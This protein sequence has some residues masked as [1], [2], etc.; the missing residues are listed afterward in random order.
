MARQSCVEPI[1]VVWWRR[2]MGESLLRLFL[3]LWLEF[4]IPTLEEFGDDADYEGVMI[5]IRWFMSCRHPEG[6]V[7]LFK[8]FWE[9]FLNLLA[10]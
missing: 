5:G 6:G 3:H 9:I 8:V 7:G 1:P 10:V 2:A 4:Q